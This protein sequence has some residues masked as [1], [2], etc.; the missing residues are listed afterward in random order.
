MSVDIAKNPV[1]HT[2]AMLNEVIEHLN[3]KP[4]QTVI[5]A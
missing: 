5:D 4:G 1:Y 2:P 3:L